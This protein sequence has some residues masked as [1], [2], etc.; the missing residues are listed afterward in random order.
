MEQKVEP[1]RLSILEYLSI[2]VSLI[3]LITVVSSMFFWFHRTNELPA[4]VTTTEQRLDKLEAQMIEN[5]TK[6]DL[7]Y[8][9]VLEIRSVLLRR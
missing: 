7:I 1:K 4:R 9:S 5:S 3:T 8:S 2:I 6:T